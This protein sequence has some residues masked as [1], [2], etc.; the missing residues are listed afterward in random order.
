M[1]C[2]A[3]LCSSGDRIDADGEQALIGSLKGEPNDSHQDTDGSFIVTDIAAST[4][5]T[6]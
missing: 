6:I 5:F 4:F 1:R 2:C 3:A